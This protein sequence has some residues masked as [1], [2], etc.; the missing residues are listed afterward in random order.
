M[1][2]QERALPKC[3]D[4]VGSGLLFNVI[5]WC[6]IKSSY[7]WTLK[8]CTTAQVQKNIL[9]VYIPLAICVCYAEET[10]ETGPEVNA[11]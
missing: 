6:R 4:E 10:L 11:T 5:V 3:C 1:L 7:N 8:P 2:R 9:Y